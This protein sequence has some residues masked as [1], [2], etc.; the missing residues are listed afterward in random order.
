[1]N[2]YTSWLLDRLITRAVEDGVSDLER[3]AVWGKVFLLG[4]L[5]GVMKVGS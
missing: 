3:L 5:G 4:S 2:L 1:V